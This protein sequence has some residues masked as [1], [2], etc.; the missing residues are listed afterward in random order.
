MAPE[1]T[2]ILYTEY[3][4][5]PRIRDYG[6]GFHDG[7]LRIPDEGPKCAQFVDP[8]VLPWTPNWGLAANGGHVLELR[9]ASQDAMT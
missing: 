8:V 2:L 6:Q 7:D 3:D 5:A 4:G 1:L 9:G